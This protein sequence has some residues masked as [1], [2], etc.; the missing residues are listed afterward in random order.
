M[1]E[2]WEKK[3]VEEMIYNREGEGGAVTKGEFMNP[4]ANHGILR[5]KCYVGFV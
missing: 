2:S 5:K 3:I 4:Y 1:N